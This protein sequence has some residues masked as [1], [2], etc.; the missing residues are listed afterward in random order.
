MLRTLGRH[1]QL[2]LLALL[3][4]VVLW[5]FVASAQR[6]EIALAVPVE[7]GGLEGPMVLAGPHREMVEVHLQ[8]GRGAAERV[9]PG[10]VR[11]R[12][13]VTRLHEGDNL[14]S[15]Q[16]ENVEAPLGVR[17]TRLA[18]A[19]TTVRLV[20]AA[21]KTVP[22][23]AR[24]Q[25]RPAEDHVLRRVVVEPATVLIKGPRTTIEARSAVDTLPVDVSGRREAMTRTVGLAL[26]ESVYP[27]DQR[28]VAVTVDI[29][30]EETMRQA[31][32]GT[33]RR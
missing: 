32:S 33:T 26:P 13:D 12:V 11:V 3:L 19:W 9:R 5:L 4:A 15:L 6:V 2:K 18:P 27:V 21:T 1:W 17:V 24:L 7:Y 20:Q 25:G 22:V 28:T 10:S 30:P 14:V 16:P 29:Q 23:V 31:P 8:A